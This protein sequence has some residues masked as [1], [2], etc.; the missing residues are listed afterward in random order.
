MILAGSGQPGNGYRQQLNKWLTQAQRIVAENVEQL[1]RSE[2]W[3]ELAKWVWFRNRLEEAR[4]GLNNP[5]F[6]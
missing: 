1:E 4:N 6:E 3:N 2:R 5:I